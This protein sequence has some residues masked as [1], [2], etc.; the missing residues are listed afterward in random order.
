[1]C[2]DY[3]EQIGNK[4][5]KPPYVY[6][7]C[8]SIRRYPL[9]KKFSYAK[10]A[11]LDYERALSECRSGI[12]ITN[13]EF[14]ELDS[15]ISPLIKKV[16]LIYHILISNAD[17][18][19]WSPKTIYTYINKEL[20]QARP[21]DL[22]RAVHGKPKKYKS[23]AHKVDTKCRHGRSLDDYGKYLCEHPESVICQI[24]IV[25]KKVQMYHDAAVSVR[26]T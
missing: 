19:S 17:K 20:L 23:I 3:E 1:M 4:L 16:Q 10:E 5:L 9:Q 14:E 15:L 18:I 11:Q 7:G 12:M 21:I 8:D 25:K 13:D 2:P 6:N 26:N 24:D 22:P